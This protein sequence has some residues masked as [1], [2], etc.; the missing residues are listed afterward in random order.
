V[1][2]PPPLAVTCIYCNGQTRL[3]CRVNEAPFTCLWKNR[4][5]SIKTCT[6]FTRSKAGLYCKKYGS[7]KYPCPK[8]L[9]YQ[10]SKFYLATIDNSGNC[11][12][13]T[14]KSNLWECGHSGVQCR[15]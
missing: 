15:A 7:K 6:S 14:S 2:S 8:Y 12:V 1:R 3:S 9:V 5:K 11:P 10:G 13:H 4:Y